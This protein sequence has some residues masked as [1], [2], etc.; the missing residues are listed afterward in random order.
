MVHWSSAEISASQVLE[1]HP[2]WELIEVTVPHS[3]AAKFIR[4]A[5]DL[6]DDF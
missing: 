4:L 3:G 6:E 2:D 1:Q 5:I